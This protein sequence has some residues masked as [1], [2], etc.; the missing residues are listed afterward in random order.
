MATKLARPHGFTQGRTSCS[1]AIEFWT[2]LNLA[3]PTTAHHSRE[4]LLVVARDP[5][6]EHGS[7]GVPETPLPPASDMSRELPFRDNSY[8]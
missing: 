8:G 1:H 4:Q 6:R 5:S 7:T 3:P 2:V